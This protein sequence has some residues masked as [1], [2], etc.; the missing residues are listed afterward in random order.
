MHGVAPEFGGGKNKMSGLAG[1]FLVFLLLAGGIGSM[2]VLVYRDNHYQAS[3]ISEHDD[4][5]LKRQQND[6]L[7]YGGASTGAPTEPAKGSTAP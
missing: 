7:R 6:N 5:N 4:Y 1:P 2:V 3:A